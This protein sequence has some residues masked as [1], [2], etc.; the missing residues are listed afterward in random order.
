MAELRSE[1]GFL[2]V[3]GAPLYYEVTGQGQP[4]LFIHAG[5]AD[6]RMWDEQLPIFAQRYQV[7]RYDLRGYGK[8]QIPA[9][10]FANHE[11]AAALLHFLNIEKACVVGVSFGGRVAVDFALVHPE[12]V[13]ALVLSAPS[14]G[15]TEPSEDVMGFAQEEEALLEAGDLEA[16]TNLNVRFWV[17]GPGRTPDQVNPEVR[18]RVYEMQYHAFTVP[19]PA[20]AEEAEIEPPAMQRLAEI[21][22]PT[23]I[24]VGDCDLPGKVVQAQQ[25]AEQ[26][27]FAQLEIVK[28][29]AHMVSMERPE[30]FNRLVLDF[31]EKHPVSNEQNFSPE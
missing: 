3:Q 30:E 20:E 28:G 26:I 31:L 2:D 8:S 29:A 17:D 23:L 12:M 10:R 5:I 25:L 14:I 27:P 7:I 1:S 16:A 24:I 18:R 9:G 21:R 22:V 13:S 4:V 15:G 6:S 19:I 11:D